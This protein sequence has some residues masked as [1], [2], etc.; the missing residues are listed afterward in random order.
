MAGF[1]I[2]EVNDKRIKAIWGK[3][4]LRD[5][6]INGCVIKLIESAST[7]DLFKV[8]AL[9]IEE[10]KLKKYKPLIL[11]MPRHQITVRNARYPSTDDNELNNIIKLNLPQQVPYAKEDIIYSYSTLWRTSKGFSS[12]VLAIL[13]KEILRKQFYIFEK[14]NMYP[15]NVSMSTMGL[16]SFLQ[17]AKIARP[18]DGMLKAFLD[19]DTEYSDLLI[20]R[21][22]ELLFTKSIGLGAMQLNMPDV[23]NR[24]IT[25]IK[26]AMISF[27]T[28]ETRAREKLTRI[29]MSGALSSLFDLPK[30]LSNEFQLPADIINPFD[31]VNSLGALKAMDDIS[32]NASINMLLGM[33]SNPLLK[34]MN[35]VLPEAKLKK[36]VQDMAKNLIVTGT[37]VLYIIVLVILSLMG[38]ISIKEGYLNNIQERVHM[39]ENRNKDAI[40]ALD[41]MKT[42]RKFSKEEDSFLFNYRELAKIVP[43]NIT[44]DRIIFAKDKEFSLVGKGTDMGEIFKFVTVLNDAKI[45]GKTELRYSRK[46]TTSNVEFNE[47]EVVCT[48]NG[49]QE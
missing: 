4:V 37:A 48:F 19:V 11:C 16:M 38:K 29:Y 20:F 33:A 30:R 2:F 17:K 10:K 28:V 43:M 39:L 44:I 5:T 9:I 47:F 7:E 13:H 34:K 18:Q 8:I 27:R 22:T 36:D 26:Q 40:V 15:E 21:G 12:V 6:Q 41:K 23:M 45:F 1:L 25:E 24:F 49:A 46:K 14:L 42:L 32:G 3:N 35:F 31:V